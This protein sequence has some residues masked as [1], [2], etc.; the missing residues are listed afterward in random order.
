MSRKGAS[1]TEDETKNRP[2]ILLLG[3]P[4]GNL[5]MLTLPLL[6][7]AGNEGSGLSEEILD[8]CDANV[9]ID[10][11]QSVDSL[12]VSVAAGILLDRLSAARCTT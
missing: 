1:G 4:F 12:N 3:S 8:L 10:G 11:V 2:I 7:C 9:V 6:F 5:P